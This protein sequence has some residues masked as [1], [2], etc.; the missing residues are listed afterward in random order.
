MAQFIDLLSQ[1]VVG[2]FA[3]KLPIGI[4]IYS[5]VLGL[6]LLYFVG[7]FVVDFLFGD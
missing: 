6:W 5:L 3:I 2:L 4:S 1:F 7:K